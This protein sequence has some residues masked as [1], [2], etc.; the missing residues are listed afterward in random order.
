MMQWFAHP[1]RTSYR[2]VFDGKVVVHIVKQYETWLVAGCKTSRES[3]INPKW[4]T[5]IPVEQGPL[6]GSQLNALLEEA[7]EQLQAALDAI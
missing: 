6:Q 3:L 4:D 7:R 1:E 2:V 5:S